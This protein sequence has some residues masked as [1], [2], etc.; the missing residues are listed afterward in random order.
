M[1]AVAFL[2]LAACGMAMYMLVN[3]PTGRV[4]QE[5]KPHVKNVEKSA[6]H[7]MNLRDFTEFGMPLA[8]WRT[9]NLNVTNLN[10][11]WKPRS[12]P[13]QSP[14]RNLYDIFDASAERQSYLDKFGHLFYIRAN[15]GQIPLTGAEGGSLTIQLPDGSRNS[16]LWND[17]KRV[18]PYNPL[19]YRDWLRWNPHIY[20]V[21]GAPVYNSNIGQPTEWETPTGEPHSSPVNENTNPLGPGGTFQ[22]IYRAS[23]QRAAFDKFIARDHVITPPPSN[24]YNAKFRG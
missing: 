21:G 8:L 16:T 18:L 6:S 7:R 14:T 17:T 1:A 9:D 11:A 23:N 13:D 20:A 3:N 4:L 19:V 15:D 10:N 22:S 12:A 5:Q 2:G 24:Y